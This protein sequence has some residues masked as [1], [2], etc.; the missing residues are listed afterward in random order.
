MAAAGIKNRQRRG[1]VSKQITPAY[2]CDEAVCAY[3]LRTT[4]IEYKS[5]MRHEGM[6]RTQC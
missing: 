5:L 6:A 3:F 2:R 1:F 4:H